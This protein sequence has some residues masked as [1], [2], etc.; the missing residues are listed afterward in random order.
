MKLKLIK[1]FFC[2]AITFSLAQTELTKEIN[3]KIDGMSCAI[4]CAQSIQNELNNTT[5]IIA[6]V[7]FDQS[8]AIITYNSEIV[9][10]NQILEIIN[11]YQ[12]GKFKASLLSTETR[13]CSEGK[14]CCKK[15]GKKNTNCTKRCCSS[16]KKGCKKK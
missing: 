8:Q 14:K 16:S 5:G 6:S 10:N 9:S 12:D 13:A 4:G 3:V 1:L 2:F 11:T 15:T 7:D